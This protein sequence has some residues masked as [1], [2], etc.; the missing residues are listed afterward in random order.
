[1]RSSFLKETSNIFL[2]YSLYHSILGFGFALLKKL[3]LN[4]FSLA[5]TLSCL[6]IVITDFSLLYFCKRKGI[7]INEN[8]F[9]AQ[10]KISIFDCLST[11][12]SNFSL[13]VNPV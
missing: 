13:K 2:S 1:M 8:Y 7:K 3:I 6:Q 9:Q 12:L 5:L 4:H 11:F 10:L